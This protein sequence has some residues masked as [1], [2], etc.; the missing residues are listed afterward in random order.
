MRHTLSCKQVHL[1]FCVQVSYPTPRTQLHAAPAPLGAHAVTNHSLSTP[2][3]SPLPSLCRCHRIP[4]CQGLSPGHH[5]S[6]TLTRHS[7]TTL[8]QHTPRFQE[9]S[10]SSAPSPRPCAS[11]RRH[12]HIT[13]SPPPATT[14]THTTSSLPP[15]LPCRCHRLLARQGPSPR[16]HWRSGSPGGA[17]PFFQHPAQHVVRRAGVWGAGPCMRRRSG[18]AV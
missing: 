15:L 11:P 5:H 18:G 13:P 17:H 6:V 2:S 16:H 10:A 1:L 12:T 3:F 7:F 4:A 9:P 8:P 14:H